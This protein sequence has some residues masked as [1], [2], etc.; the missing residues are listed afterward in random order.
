M[1]KGFVLYKQIWSS[2]EGLPE[3]EILTEAECEN[4]LRGG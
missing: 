1:R 3:A 2:K 4:M